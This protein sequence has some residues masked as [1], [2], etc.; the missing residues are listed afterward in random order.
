MPKKFLKKFI[1]NLPDGFTKVF[2][3]Y[4]KKHYPGV[5]RSQFL[6][7]LL[8][9]YIDNPARFK[10]D[11]KVILNY[12]KLDRSKK[13]SFYFLNAKY[14][15]KF[16]EMALSEVRKENQQALLFVYSL[17]HLIEENLLTQVYDG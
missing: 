2:D 5:T 1:V 12:Q 9:F 14:H 16:K 8:E 10:I 11:N 3:D 13:A 17:H 15:E 7:D 4:V 6:N